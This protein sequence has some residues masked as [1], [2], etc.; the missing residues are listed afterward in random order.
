MD[1]FLEKFYDAKYIDSRD[2]SKKTGKELFS[3]RTTRNKQLNGDNLHKYRK[4]KVS[5][6]KRV[7]RKSHYPIQPN[8]IIIWK[9]RLW[10]SKGAHN[11]GTRVMLDGN[12]L[13]KAKSVVIKDLKVKNT[14][15]TIYRKD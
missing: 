4:Q 1:T 5:K 8:D 7:I 6:G 15:K 2:G 10:T 11:N 12:N 13:K 3:G 9:N 14:A